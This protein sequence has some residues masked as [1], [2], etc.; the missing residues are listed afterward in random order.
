MNHYEYA[1]VVKTSIWCLKMRKMTKTPLRTLITMKRSEV[2]R[3][4]GYL[5]IM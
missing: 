5:W 3:M 4:V 1:T 2:L